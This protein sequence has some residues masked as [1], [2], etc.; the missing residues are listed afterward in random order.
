M[1]KIRLIWV[2]ILMLVFLP[3]RAQEVDRWL[4]LYWE[5]QFKAN[6]YKAPEINGISPLASFDM[7][8]T[9]SLTVDAGLRFQLTKPDANKRSWLTADFGLGNYNS[10]YDAL[11]PKLLTGFER[12]FTWTTTINALTLVSSMGLMQDFDIKKNWGIHVAAGVRVQDMFIGRDQF[13]HSESVVVDGNL[14]SVSVVGPDFSEPFFEPNQRPDQNLGF[15]Q[16][17]RCGLWFTGKRNRIYR[18]SI[19]ASRS[20]FNSIGDFPLRFGAEGQFEANHSFIGIALGQN[21]R[22]N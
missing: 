19:F 1:I 3:T 15:G 22:L 12:D 18:V 10:T 7:K 17:L 16:Y 6:Q 4:P 11:V 9:R 20:R 13:N 8:E 2:G 5:F 21:M 14:T